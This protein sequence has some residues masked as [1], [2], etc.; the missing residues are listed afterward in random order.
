M[1][2]RLQLETISK[3][4]GATKVLDGVTLDV[5][6]GEFVSLVGASG[7]GKS[8]LLRVIAGLETQDCGGVSIAERSVDALSP[9]ARN[10]AMVF[11]NYA[12]YPH[13]S[14][15]DN[16]ALPLAVSRLTLAERLP[17]LRLLS[18]RRARIARE[19]ARKSR[20]W[21]RN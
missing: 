14:V 9:R 21:P 20:T 11:Q 18:P 10:I 4:F 7:C 17:L 6:P 15:F 12:L 1:S 2:A 3:S 8:T 5:Q 16:I 19:I 13:M